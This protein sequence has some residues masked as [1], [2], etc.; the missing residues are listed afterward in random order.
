M[1]NCNSK[2]RPCKFKEFNR[3]DK[4]LTDG[5]G[6]FH[7]WGVDYENCEGNTGN[8]SVGIVEKA[9]GTVVLIPA[10]WIQFTVKE[11]K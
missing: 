11:A 6:M 7:Q 9:D 2:L 10:E 1:C 5:E 3:Y 8:Y 4:T